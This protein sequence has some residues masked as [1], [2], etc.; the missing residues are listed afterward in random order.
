MSFIYIHERCDKSVSWQ[1]Q[2]SHVSLGAH[3]FTF[4]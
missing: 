1:G 3:V 2:D 4:L